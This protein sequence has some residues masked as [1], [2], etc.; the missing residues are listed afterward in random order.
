MNKRDLIKRLSSQEFKFTMRRFASEVAFT[1]KGLVID[2]ERFEIDF[3]FGEGGQTLIKLLLDVVTKEQTIEEL[4]DGLWQ[5]FKQCLYAK[6][7]TFIARRVRRKFPVRTRWVTAM[8]LFPEL[9]VPEEVLG[10][11]FVTLRTVDMFS[12]Q[13]ALEKQEEEEDVPS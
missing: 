8:H 12:L 11:E 3:T 7:P 1:Y 4:P 5:H 10:K 2:P 9:H 13:D 6:L